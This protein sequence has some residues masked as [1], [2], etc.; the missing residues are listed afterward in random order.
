M[1]VYF[2]TDHAGY[3]MKESLLSYVR[4]ELGH[5]VEDCGAILFDEYD[6]YPDFVVVAAKNV[7]KDK[8]SMGIILGASGQGEAVVANRV[9]GVRAVV[10]YGE[11]Q[12]W[13]IDAC[14]EEMDMVMSTR[15]HNDANILSLGARFIS[16]EEAK[17]VVKKWLSTEFEHEDRH[18][19]RINKID[20]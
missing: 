15:K 16:I 20:T 5:E 13:Q 2:A 10:Y 12:R 6:D 7:A 17:E 8:G 11:P 14:G 4:D 3:D 18:V 9:P 19:R 1:K